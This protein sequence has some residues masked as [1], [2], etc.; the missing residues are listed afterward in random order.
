MQQEDKREAEERTESSA[1]GGK[2]SS[3]EGEPRKTGSQRVE[4]LSRFL[5]HQQEVVYRWA[6][7]SVTSDL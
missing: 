1:D 4:Q 7:L 3:A 6:S 2:D 5:R